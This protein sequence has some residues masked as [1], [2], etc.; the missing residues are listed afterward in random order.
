LELEEL[1]VK[2]FQAM[3]ES[4]TLPQYALGIYCGP[5]NL[6]SA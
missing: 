6:E 5:E 4:D 3:E 1:G 2:V